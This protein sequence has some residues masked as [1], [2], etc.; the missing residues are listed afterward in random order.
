MGCQIPRVGV[1]PADS[2]EGD[3]AIAL[4][5]AYELQPDEWQEKVVRSWLEVRKD[6]KWK[7]PRCGIAV[8]RQNGKN[9]I[10]EIIELF[11]MV[12][13]AEKFLHTAHEVK[14]ARKA[15]I[16]L[17]YFF[18]EKANDPTA[19]FPELNQLVREVRNT[20]GQ[21]AI[22]LVNGGSCEFI[23]RSKGSGRGFTVDK[24]VLDE[25]QELSEESLAALM[26]TMS[27][28]PSGNPQMI[29]AGTPPDEGMAGDAFTRMRN[30]GVEGQDRRLSWFEWSCLGVVDLDD[31][32]VWAA[33]NPALGMRLNAETIEDERAAMDDETFMRERLGMWSV[34]G[35]QRVIS[36][37][38]WR[39]VAKS[40]LRD[41]GAAVALAVDVS[42]DRDT[43]TI[44]A[45]TLENSGL[46]YIDVIESRRGSPAWVP[47]RIAEIC[48]GSDVRA[49]VIDN[50]GAA[51]SLIEPLLKR[52]VKVTETNARDMAKACGGLY[53]AVM[54]AKVLHLDQPSLNHAVAVA[55]K[56]RLGDA[57][58]WN[59][60][61][62]DS[63]ITPL[64]GATLALW[65]FEAS[66]VKRPMRSNVR[67]K[68]VVLG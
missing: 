5:S 45:V 39:T 22:V 20:N 55:R 65:G 40:N 28:A 66:G 2:P 10:I 8:P 46:P 17:K 11:G 54:D 58:A 27:A 34:S 24:L 53:D 1:E 36:A 13:R 23:A 59:R 48:K 57:W 44:V 37:D 19:R 30:S 25:A 49:V 47:E 62:A 51:S 63:D 7:H 68:A 43:S 14:T 9:G 31:P 50:A 26:P 18:G 32:H 29:L 33:A 6:G 15:F 4:S 3:D 21:E 16:R 52:R 64:V 38:A 67:R 12:L 56:R 35:V 60:K 61:D 42:P 41:A